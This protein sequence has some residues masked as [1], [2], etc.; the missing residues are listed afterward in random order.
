VFISLR[1]LY[2]LEDYKHKTQTNTNTNTNTVIFT[3]NYSLSYNENVSD[4]NTKNV[5]YITCLLESMYNK[6]VQ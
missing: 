3:I 6:I 5:T 2:I 1:G 4:Y